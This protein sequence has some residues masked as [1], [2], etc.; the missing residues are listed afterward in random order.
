MSLTTESFDSFLDLPEQLQREA[1]RE[2]ELRIQA[3]LTV[4]AAADQ[5]ALTWAGFVITGATA[6]F[7]AGFAIIVSAEGDDELTVLALV[8]GTALLV[9]AGIAVWSVRPGLFCLPGN[10][11]GLWLPGSWKCVGSPEAKIAQSRLDQAAQLDAHIRENANAA[12]DRAK[13]MR[14][15]MGIAFFSIGA[16]G[17]CLAL[18]ASST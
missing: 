15:S 5:R 16:A 8:I 14:T 11:P 6:L 10:R 7:A 17:I 9:S 18:Y 12:G 4:A 13:L 2:G 3:Q 1:L